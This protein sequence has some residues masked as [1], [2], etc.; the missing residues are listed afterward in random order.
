MISL[1]H[2]PHAAYV[3]AAYGVS[4]AGLA[5]MSL[6]TLWRA[7]R[8]KAAERR[9]AR[10]RADR[11]ASAAAPSARLDGGDARTPG[12]VSESDPRSA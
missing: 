7:A 5:A 9:Q 3:L 4:A 1:P 10:L 11:Q 6:D 8:W 2:G 12:L